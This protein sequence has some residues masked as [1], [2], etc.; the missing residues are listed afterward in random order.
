M[1]VVEPL[2]KAFEILEGTG[3]S[4]KGIRS[5]GGAGLHAGNLFHVGL[6]GSAK[7]GE[8][9]CGTFPSGIPGDAA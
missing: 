9:S 1:H 4:A 3:D 2:L 6:A 5:L 7:A 8:V